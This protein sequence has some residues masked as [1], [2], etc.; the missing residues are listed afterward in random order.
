MIWFIFFCSFFFSLLLSVS[1]RSPLAKIWS[2]FL[3][4]CIL[5]DIF[6]LLLRCW[7]RRI[8]IIADIENFLQVGL[9][10]KKEMSQNFY[11]P[12][13]QRNRTPDQILIHCFARIPFRIISNLFLLGTTIKHHLKKRD[14]SNPERHF[15][16][17]L[18]HYGGKRIEAYQMYIMCK[19]KF[20]KILINLRGCKSSSTKA[21]NVFK[22][23]EIKG[24]QIKDLEQY[25]NSVKSKIMIRTDYFKNLGPAAWKR[26]PLVQIASI[27]DSFR[28]LSPVTMKMPLFLKQLWKQNKDWDNKMEEED[29][30][31]W[32]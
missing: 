10:Q 32:R 27:I 13:T 20:K 26:Q 2:W 23:D 25:W 8:G 21:N 1:K 18:N 5:V 19:E 17:Q 11:G 14:K 9:N 24:S 30:N 22:E 12:K 29:L 7:R 31:T 16:Q 3:Q 15:C 4:A 6:G 28:Y